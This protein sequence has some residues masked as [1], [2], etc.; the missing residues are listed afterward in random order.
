MSQQNAQVIPVKHI[1]LESQPEAIRQFLLALSIPPEGA[2]F[3]L[4]GEPVACVFSAPKVANGAGTSSEEWSEAK[5]D[6][7]CDLIDR[8]YAGSLTPSEESELTSLQE[9]MLRYRQRVA[10]I[11][12]EDARLL[13]QQLL[14]RAQQASN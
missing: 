14:M 11:P 13:H 2:V 7:R 5:N 12:L 10:P 8:K 6:R 1:R 3:E 4:G 9:Q